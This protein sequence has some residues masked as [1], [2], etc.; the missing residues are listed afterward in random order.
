MCETDRKRALDAVDILND[1]KGDLITGVMVLREY[2]QELNTGQISMVQMVPIQKMCVSH[3]VLTF[4][5]WL[6]FY[7]RYHGLVP[8]EYRE[9][10]KK[11]NRILNDKKVRQFRNIVVGHLWDKDKKRP[12]VLS[13]IMPKLEAIMGPKPSDFFKWVSNPD[14]NQYPETLISVVEKVRDVL[15]SKYSIT[16]QE[17]IE[18]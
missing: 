1:F 17:V 14:N 7:D 15:M 2:S 9:E 10:I 18:R 5:K 11:K 13:E 16:P 8:D 6:E 4:S 3:L 12:L